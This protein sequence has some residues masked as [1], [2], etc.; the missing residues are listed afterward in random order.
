MAITSAGS[1]ITAQNKTAGSSDIFQITTAQSGAVTKKLF[2]VVIAKDN[3]AAA[4]G[5]TSEVTGILDGK[6][7]TWVKLK[8]FCNAQGSADAGATV[9]VWACVTTAAYTTADTIT[10]SYSDSRTATAVTGW[11]FNIGATTTAVNLETYL[12]EATTGAD[13]AGLN[14]TGLSAGLE[15]LFIRA[16]ASEAAVTTHT[17]STVDGT[18]TAFTETAST[19][20]GAGAATNMGAR[21]EFLIAS[22]VTAKNNNPTF[23]AVDI[24]SIHM[25]L[26]EVVPAAVADPLGMSGY[27][28]A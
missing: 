25:A 13:A 23:T 3:A 11:A 6:S 24:A 1:L 10:V 21:G 7:G 4:N 5:E 16:A 2:I 12:T 15:Y 27:Y 19:T 14:L 22:G 9:S 18:Y 26:T 8:E 20:S 28:G 17:A